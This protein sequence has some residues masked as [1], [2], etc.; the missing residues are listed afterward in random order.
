MMWLD[1]PQTTN[2]LCRS[3]LDTIMASRVPCSVPTIKRVHTQAS[4]VNEGTPESH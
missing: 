1:F 2:G 3:L 4:H